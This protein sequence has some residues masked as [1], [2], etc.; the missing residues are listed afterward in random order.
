MGPLCQN[1]R[2]IPDLGSNSLYFL[3]FCCQNLQKFGVLGS[4]SMKLM[5]KPCVLELFLSRPAKTRGFRVKLSGFRV[6]NLPFSRISGQHLWFSGP[7]LTSHL[8]D[9]GN[10]G[11]ASWVLKFASGNLGRWPFWAKSWPGAFWSQTWALWGLPPG[12]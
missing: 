4:F 10:L 9:F 8:S 2:C 7:T 5:Q 11:L 3:T 6:Q 1:G 12:S